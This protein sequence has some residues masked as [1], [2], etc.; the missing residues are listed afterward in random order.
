MNT[1]R[2]FGSYHHAA[3]LYGMKCVCLCLFCV[4]TVG[5]AT[6]ILLLGDSLINGRE[7]L[8]QPLSQHFKS[9][10]GLAGAGY[11]SFVDSDG[12]ADADIGL[13]PEN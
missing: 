7:R 13:H 2:E 3:F 9:N 8:A 12:S 5:A 6:D 10:G 11:C 1:G 4:S